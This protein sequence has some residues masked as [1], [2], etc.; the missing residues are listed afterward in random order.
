MT[1][2]GQAA[3]MEPL[4][5]GVPGLLHTLP[6]AYEEDCLGQNANS[7]STEK[8]QKRGVP[9]WEEGGRRKG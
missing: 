3:G 6:V 9:R 8:H 1:V 5:P 2:S 7:A 4:G